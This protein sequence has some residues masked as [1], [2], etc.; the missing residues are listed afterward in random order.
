[1]ISEEIK[2]EILAKLGK[3][4]EAVA[5][6]NKRD[7]QGLISKCKSI[8]FDVTEGDITEFIVGSMGELSDDELNAVSGG[9]CI[10]SMDRGYDC[11]SDTCSAYEDERVYRS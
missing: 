10:F 3:D 11:I 8:G 1:M 2:K 4:K 9:E 5:M 6:M 7:V